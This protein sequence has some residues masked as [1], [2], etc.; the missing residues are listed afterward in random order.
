METLTPLKRAAL[1]IGRLFN[2]DLKP[3]GATGAE[4]SVLL[5]N[6]AEKRHKAY[7]VS[8]DLKKW[9]AFISVFLGTMMERYDYA[10]A[11][12]SCL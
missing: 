7:D 12:R 11:T 4:S 10:C 1:F 8:V 2:P 9:R 3:A 5:K 6:S